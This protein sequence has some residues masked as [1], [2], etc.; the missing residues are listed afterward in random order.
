LKL[1]P[2]VLIGG[3][4]IYYMKRFIITEEEKKSIRGMYLLEQETTGT[5]PQ[6]I[7]DDLEKCECG[8]RDQEIQK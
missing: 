2:P 1:F 7:K 6:L 3:I 8:Y 4:F 5:T